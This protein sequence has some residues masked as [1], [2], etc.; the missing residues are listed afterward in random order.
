LE[1]NVGA[2][3]VTLTA[4]ELKRIE[5]IWPKGAAAGERYAKA[6]MKAVGL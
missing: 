5:S 3:E 2:L 4:E 6:G 1:E